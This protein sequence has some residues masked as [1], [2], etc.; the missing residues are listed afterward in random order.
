MRLSSEGITF[1]KMRN[2]A[3]QRPRISLALGE[4]VRYQSMAFGDYARLDF[5]GAPDLANMFQYKHDFNDRYCASR[6][7]AATKSLP[8]ELQD[9]DRWLARHRET[10]RRCVDPQIHLKHVDRIFKR[11][12]L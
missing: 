9:F 11:V 1:T 3:S 8:P 4:P 7:V 6:P 10:L 2:A 12:G 5:P